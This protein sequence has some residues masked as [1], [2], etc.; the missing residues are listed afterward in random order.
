MKPNLMLSRR[1]VRPR[2]RSWCLSP[3]S[4]LLLVILFAAAGMTGGTCAETLLP[5][6]GGDGG[7]SGS[8]DNS[9]VRRPVIL[10][11]D[12]V[13]GDPEAPLVVFE[14][15]SYESAACGKFARLEFPTIKEQYIDTG[16]IRWV[17]RHFPLSTD[18]RAG[19]AA[20]AAECAHDQGRFVEY[21]DL[22]YETTDDD[23]LVILTDEMLQQHATTLGLD[24]T[25]FDACFA[26]D[27]KV[28]RISQ[29]S[30]SGV[31]LG[32][33]TVPAFFVGSELVSE[34]DTADELGEAI[35]RHLSGG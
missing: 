20:R 25:Q 9:A 21:R 5:A 15:E 24:R 10:E 4:A 6:D 31:A 35:G 23:G 8:D 14:Y 29:D 22:I 11:S 7:G 16:K 34:V 1:R 2:P 18:E 13:L 32:V 19:P 17:F 27:F 12:H 3:V 30:M 26:G 28:S 33:S